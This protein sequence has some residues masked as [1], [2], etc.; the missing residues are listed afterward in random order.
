M[1]DYN[2][3]DIEKTRRL[4]LWGGI[5]WKRI[6]VKYRNNGGYEISRPNT[7]K[8]NLV[9]PI[10]GKLNHSNSNLEGEKELEQRKTLVRISYL[11]LRKKIHI[12]QP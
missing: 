10:V 4:N 11:L 9:S 7:S 6:Y 12:D 2:F 8:P 1:K 5:L 3:V